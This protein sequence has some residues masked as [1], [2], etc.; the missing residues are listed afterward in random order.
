M[1]SLDRSTPFK[2]TFPYDPAYLT[3]HFYTLDLELPQSHWLSTLMDAKDT[4]WIQ[5]DRIVKINVLAYY[6]GIYYTGYMPRLRW[7]SAIGGQIHMGYLSLF[8]LRFD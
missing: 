5:G 1:S 3:Y 8:A 4:E 2:H 6:L 7:I